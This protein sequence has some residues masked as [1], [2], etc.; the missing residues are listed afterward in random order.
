M[1]LMAG[2]TDIWEGYIPAQDEGDTVYYYIEATSNSGKTQVR[3]MPAPHGYW[4]FEVAPEDVTAI[5][6]PPNPPS[7]L[8]AVYPNPASGITYIPVYTDVDD[9]IA[10]SGYSTYRVKSSTLF[11]QGPLIEGETTFFVNTSDMSAGVYWL[12]LTAGRSETVRKIGD[13]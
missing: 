13:R 10:P 9:D 12:E 5:I 7:F 8:K 11:Y 3:P 2:T 1:S 6:Q 4:H